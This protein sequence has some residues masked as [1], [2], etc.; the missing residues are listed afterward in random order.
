M[1]VKKMMQGNKDS[2]QGFDGFK[3]PPPNDEDKEAMGDMA[4]AMINR[5][6]RTFKS[7]LRDP[8]Y[9]GLTIAKLCG[10]IA[11]YELY[12]HFFCP[13]FGITPVNFFSFFGAI[14]FIRAIKILL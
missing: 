9:I 1:D 5:W 2:T 8:K 10:F 4:I 7:K 3:M 13:S 11:M 6:K 12:R 14:L